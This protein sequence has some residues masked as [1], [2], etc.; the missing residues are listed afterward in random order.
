[1]KKTERLEIRLTPREKEF[2]SALAEELGIT[3]TKLLMIGATL[4]NDDYAG[5]RLKREQ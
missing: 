3:I 5:G 1:M 4:V 2:L